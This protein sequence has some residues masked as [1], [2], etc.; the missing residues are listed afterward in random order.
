MVNEHPNLVR[1]YSYKNL[2]V[3]TAILV[4]NPFTSTHLVA[5]SIATKMY[6][7]PINLHV[8][9]IRPIKFRPHFVKG[10]FRSIVTN[11]AK[12]FVFNPPIF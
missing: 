1:I 7:F 3:T 12:L 10:S 6:L 8:G 5:Q 11:L 4:L 2:V 9:L